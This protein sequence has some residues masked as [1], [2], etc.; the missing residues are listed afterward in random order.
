MVYHEYAHGLSE[1][2]VTDAQGFGALIGAQPGAIA[3][4][5]S[6]YYAMDYLVADRARPRAGHR[7]A[8][9]SAR[10]RAAAGQH[11]RDRR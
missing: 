3:E 11:G 10:R 5:T 8:G 7:G 9:R 6:D 2:L 1:R 4:G